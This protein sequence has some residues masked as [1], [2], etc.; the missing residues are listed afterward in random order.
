M[1]QQSHLGRACRASRVQA[2]LLPR[3]AQLHF[4]PASNVPT[5]SNASATLT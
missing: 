2:F 5:N 1:T 3:V 4:P